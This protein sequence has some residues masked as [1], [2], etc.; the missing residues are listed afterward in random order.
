MWRESNRFSKWS[1]FVCNSP[2]NTNANTQKENIWTNFKHT[3]ATLCNTFRP[4]TKTYCLTHAQIQKWNL[5]ISLASFQPAIWYD[6]HTLFT[7]YHEHLPYTIYIRILF[8]STL[9]S[10]VFLFF[11]SWSSN[12]QNM[13]GNCELTSHSGN[14]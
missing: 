11:Y 13:K 4:T 2:Q 8:I 14:Q 7:L 3:S 10:R 12:M 5:F 9:F 1:R 6:S